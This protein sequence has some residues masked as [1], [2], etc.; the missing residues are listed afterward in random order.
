MY[1]FVNSRVQPQ[2]RP[3]VNVMPTEF[4]VVNGPVYAF[5]L[6]SGEPLW[7]APRN[8]AQSRRRAATAARY[9]VSNLRRPPNA[10]GPFNGAAAQ[11]RIL[12]LDKRTGQSVYRNDGLPDANVTRFRAGAKLILAHRWPSSGGP[13]RFNW[14]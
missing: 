7:Q 13:V 2:F 9:T 14:R 12:C 5:S 6:K 3:I 4:P 10:Q 1:L 11:L 8:G